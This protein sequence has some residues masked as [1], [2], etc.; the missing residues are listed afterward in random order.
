MQWDRTLEREDVG[1]EGVGEDEDGG[2]VKT[3]QEYLYC[4][5]AVK[6]VQVSKYAIKYLFYIILFV[7]FWCKIICKSY[8]IHIFMMEPVQ[9]LG[10][11]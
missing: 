1:E 7:E 11:C 10:L 4:A 5:L 3:S 6:A 8:R 2:G 9:L